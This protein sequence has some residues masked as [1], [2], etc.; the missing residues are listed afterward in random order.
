MVIASGIKTI[1]RQLD[2]LWR[3]TIACV[4]LA[5]CLYTK[6]KIRFTPKQRVFD[7]DG[8]FRNHHF[9]YNTLLRWKNFGGQFIFDSDFDSYIHC[10]YI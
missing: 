2:W 4:A 8:N 5:P 9:Q 1:F 7:S 3:W 10:C 6:K